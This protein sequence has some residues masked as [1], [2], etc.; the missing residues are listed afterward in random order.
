MQKELD[1]LRN[2]NLD[3][4]DTIREIRKNQL[5]WDNSNNQNNIHQTIN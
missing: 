1:Q 4:K 2:E 3:L 5:L